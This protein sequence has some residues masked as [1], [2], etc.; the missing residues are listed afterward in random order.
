MQPKAKTILHSPIVKDPSQSEP[1]EEWG[2]SP[3]NKRKKRP[4]LQ[5]RAFDIDLVFEAVILSAS[6]LARRIP[7][8]QSTTIL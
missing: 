7:R 2:F 4:G 6:Y 8:Q 3:T 1:V 5:P